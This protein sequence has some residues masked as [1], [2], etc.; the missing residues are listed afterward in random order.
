MRRVFHGSVILLALAAA[1][2]GMGARQAQ[3]PTPA[4]A[5]A[6]PNVVLIMSDDMGYADLS[7]LG[8]TDIRKPNIDGIGKAGVR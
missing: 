6:R 1:A 4:A 2:V 7:S 8:A 3:P 5:A